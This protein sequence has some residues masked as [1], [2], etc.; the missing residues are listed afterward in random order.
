MSNIFLDD[1]FLFQLKDVTVK[2]IIPSLTAFIYVD[3]VL[4]SYILTQTCVHFMHY[5]KTNP[6]P[7]KE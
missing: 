7:L 4:M 3:K 5:N 6:V 1:A 2:G